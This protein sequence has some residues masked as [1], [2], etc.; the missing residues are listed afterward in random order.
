[1]VYRFCVRQAECWQGVAEANPEGTRR[2]APK[3]GDTPTAEG[4][5]AQTYYGLGKEFFNWTRKPE[6]ELGQSDKGF[7]S[8]GTSIRGFDKNSWIEQPTPERKSLMDF[9]QSGHLKHAIG[10]Q[11]SKRYGL[12]QNIT[13]LL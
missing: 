13:S 2:K 9:R 1:M 8:W 10:L 5:N 4:G 3:H 11:K 12:E 7:K 6:A